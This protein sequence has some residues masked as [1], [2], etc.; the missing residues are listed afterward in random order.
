MSYETFWKLNPKRLEPFRVKR[1]K[2]L[3][4]QAATLDTLAWSIGSYVVDGLAMFFGRNH[5]LYPSTP[6][7]ANENENAPKGKGEVMTDGAKFAAFMV[8]HNRQL[9]ERRKQ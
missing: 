1:E 6:R 9:K 5:P 7:S 4:E 3:K 2:E 8:A